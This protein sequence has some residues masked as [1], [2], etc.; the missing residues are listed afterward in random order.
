[1]KTIQIIGTSTSIF[2]EFLMMLEAQKIACTIT[3]YGK[4]EEVGTIWKFEQK[5]LVVNVFV[6]DQ[7]DKEGIIII[8]DPYYTQE[9]F[10]SKWQAF[11][12]INLT[13][14]MDMDEIYLPFFNLETLNCQAFHIW[15]LDA[16]QLLVLYLCYYFNTLGN[17]A[18]TMFH[19]MQGIQ[20]MSAVYQQDFLQQIQAYLQQK[21]LESHC[22]PIQDE[23]HHVPLLFEVLPQTSNFLKNGNTTDEQSIQNLLKRFISNDFTSFVTCSRIGVWK[24]IAVAASFVCD[25]PIA[26]EKIEMI[27]DE[28]P[29]F[30]YMDHTQTHLFPIFSDVIHEPY[31][32]VGRLR[33]QGKNTYSLW[34]VCDEQCMRCKK[35]INILQYVMMNENGR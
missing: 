35:A 21:P 23:I 11:R 13:C 7:L 3:L 5:Y 34:A 31:I 15:I 32:F 24:G 19:T 17:L 18:I 30:R 10:A 22:F 20:E 12:T 16:K 2:K 28:I 9:R 27:L 1:M 29:I 8:C 33:S 26:K 6:M 14:A 25:K 4:Q